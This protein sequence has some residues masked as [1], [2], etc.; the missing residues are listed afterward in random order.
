MVNKDEEG[1]MNALEEVLTLYDIKLDDVAPSAEE[2]KAERYGDYSEIISKSQD[3]LDDLNQKS[4]EILAQTGMTREELESYGANPDNFT[5]EQ[6]E[7]LQK[8]KEECEKFKKNARGIVG[9]KQL[10]KTVK[11]QRKKQTHKFAKKKDWIPL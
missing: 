7:G 11:K 3:K 10:E 4:E 9:E 1:I 5:P 6:W 8:V 2:E